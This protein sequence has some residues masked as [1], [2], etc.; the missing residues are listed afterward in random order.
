[1]LGID[2]V[3]FLSRCE[4]K[5]KNRH[6]YDLSDYRHMGS[7]IKVICKKHGETTQVARTHLDSPTGC[8]GCS[9]DKI[10][11]ERKS[12]TGSFIE[13]ARKMHGDRYDYSLVEYERASIPVTIVCSL[14]GRFKQRP[15]GHLRGA[16][17]P[18]CFY[19]VIGKWNKS[20]TE[21][22]VEKA[23]RVHGDRYDYSLVEYQ[24]D[25]NKVEIIC[26]KHGV[27]KQS[28]NPHLQGQGCPNCK[29]SIGESVLAELFKKHGI[30]FIRE[31][32]IPNSNTRYRYDFFLIEHNTLVEFHGI[33]HYTPTNWF[34]GNEGFAKQLIVDQ[35]KET[36][37]K[38]FKMRL[39]VVSYKNLTLE[40]SKFEKLVMDKVK[41][42][43]GKW[44]TKF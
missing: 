3:E 22:F 15:N 24:L 40:E 23:R 44:M 17:C 35:T 13:K 1:M 8:K 30:R 42:G 29:S 38:A 25:N 11:D 32:V 2:A 43:A 7:K 31:Y 6:E 41:K 36:L 20:N 27:F 28:P 14:H 34:G 26:K 4:Q 16:R 9:H 33:Q 19:E 39:V 37:A 5:F 18:T 12:D 10:A 21:T